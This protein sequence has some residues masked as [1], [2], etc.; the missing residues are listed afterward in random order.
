MTFGP[1][2]ASLQANTIL[3]EQSTC[4]KCILTFMVYAEQISMTGPCFIVDVSV[5]HISLQRIRLWSVKQYQQ[6]HILLCFEAEIICQCY[7][8]TTP[9]FFPHN[10]AAETNTAGSHG[11]REIKR[12]KKVS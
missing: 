3:A 9:C 12:L 2:Q 1:L 6:E 8:N 11:G 10:E 4:L 5:L 7:P